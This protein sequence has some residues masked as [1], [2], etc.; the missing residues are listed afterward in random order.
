MTKLNEVK[1][2]VLPTPSWH[3]AKHE[4]RYSFS[5]FASAYGWEVPDSIELRLPLPNF[6]KEYDQG[7]SNGCVGFSACWV[8]SINNQSVLYNGMDA[9]HR[10]QEEDGDPLTTPQADNGTY[11]FAVW[12]VFKKYGPKLAKSGEIKKEHGVENYAWIKTVDEIR[13]G[14]GKGRPG[15]LYIPWGF[16]F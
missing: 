7:S 5:R 9:Y 13:T 8:Q 2:G 6:V 3:K 1:F 14:I 4:E 10:A 16:L 12:D 15:C 11:G